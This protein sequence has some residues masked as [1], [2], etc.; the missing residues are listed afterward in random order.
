MPIGDVVTNFVLDGKSLVYVILTRTELFHDS[1]LV[2]C[3]ALRDMSAAGEEGS[4]QNIYHGDAY[5]LYE[6]RPV[7][8]G[9][10]VT[11]VFSMVAN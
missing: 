3:L 2:A 11:C 7:V 10:N 4:F 6:D 1:P 5:R 8:N 9:K